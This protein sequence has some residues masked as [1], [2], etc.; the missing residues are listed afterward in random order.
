MSSTAE[1]GCSFLMI[2][3]PVNKERLPQLSTVNQLSAEFIRA[4]VLFTNWYGDVADMFRP[5]TYF[6]TTLLKKK[7]KIL[8]HCKPEF[9]MKEY[10]QKFIDDLHITK[11]TIVENKSLTLVFPL[12]GSN[13]GR[14]GLN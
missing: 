13:P 14:L 3:L 5:Y 10:F 1:T 9:F 4:L 8:K 12:V 7:K 6:Q 11:E 2:K